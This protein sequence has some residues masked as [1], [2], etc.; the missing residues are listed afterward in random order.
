MKKNGFTLVEI[1]AV[2]FILSLL[3]VIITPVVTDLV[4]D[5]EQS[6]YDKQVDNIVKAVQKYGVEHS[7]VLPDEQESTILSLHTLLGAGILDKDVIMNPKTKENMGGCVIISYSGTYSQYEYKYYE[8]CVETG[9]SYTFDYTGSYQTFVAP[10]KGR[11]KLEVWGAQGGYRSDASKGGKGGYATGSIVLNAGDTLYIYVG[12]SGSTGT[13]ENSICTGGFNGG[14]YRSVYKGGGGATDMRFLGSDNPLVQQSLLSRVIV[15]GGGGS[16][17]S[18]SQA[19]GDGGGA[20]GVAATGGYGTGG[21]GG[22]QTGFTTSNTVATSQ[23]VTNGNNYAGFGFGGYGTFQNNGYGGAGGGGWYGGVGIVP[24]SGGDDERGGGGGSGFVYDSN[25]L[26]TLP[27]DYLVQSRYILSATSIVAGNASMPNHEGTGNMT[28]NSGN[29][30]AKITLETIVN[31]AVGYYDAVG[32]EE[33]FIASK[34][35]YYELVV[36]GAQGG[37]VT[38]Y[39]GGYGS[40]SSGIVHLDEGDTLYVNVGTQGSSGN[41]YSNINGGYNGGGYVPS[42]SDGPS[43]RVVAGG[44]GAT[45]IALSSGTLASF[46]VNSNG[47]A[48]VGELDDILI[49]AGGGGGGYAHDSSGYRGIGGD[50]GGATGV[51]GGYE[52]GSCAGSGATQTAG[53]NGCSVSGTYGKFG[54]GG[55]VAGRSHG[56]AGGGGFYGGGGSKGDIMDN[57]NSGGGGGSGYIGNDL[58]YSG[59]M[60]CYGCTPNDSDGTVTISTIGSDSSLDSI[61]CGNGYS[62]TAYSKCAKAGGGY[63]KIRYLGISF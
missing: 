46:D 59:V 39:R 20:S 45:H 31:G 1:L 38:G 36:W 5:S 41:P 42:S 3:A 9:D 33:E 11:Y 10:V 17:G 18:T 30:Y 21:F 52:S 37:S 61:N 62:S 19:G 40:Y 28:G 22:T 25:S 34:S 57:G 23:S 26:A 54:I 14:G 29:G 8:E 49:V 43:G 56:S 50:A 35:G 7:E 24:D 58:L 55:N 12:G 44:G 15:A 16:D 63:A 27:S 4:K 32:H 53:G 51:S 2:I 13:C 47:A 48:D 60:Y 6:L